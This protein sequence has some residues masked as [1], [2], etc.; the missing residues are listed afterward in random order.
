MSGWGEDVGVEVEALQATYG[1]ELLL[2]EQHQQVSMVMMPAMESSQHFVQ[3]QLLLSVTPQYPQELPGIELVDV[4]GFTNRQDQLMHQLTTEASGLAGELLLGL[5]FE[6]AKTW[7]AEHNHPEGPCI[8]CLEDMAP[9]AGSQ[10]AGSTSGQDANQDTQR[11]RLPCFHAFH[12]ACF[13]DWWCW[14]QQAFTEQQRALEEKTG[15]TAAAALVQE[16][17][18]T[19]D[20]QHF[21]LA[22]PTCRQPFLLADLQQHMQQQLGKHLKQKQQQAAS[23]Q[24]RLQPIAAKLT[25]A[26]LQPFLEV[27]QQH[28]RLFAQQQQRQGIIATDTSY[29]IA[30]W[31]GPVPAGSMEPCGEQSPLAAA[32]ININQGVRGLAIDSQ[33]GHSTGDGQQYRGDTSRGRGRGRGRGRHYNNYGRADQMQQQVPYQGLQQQQQL[34]REPPQ[35]L[36][37]QQ[38]GQQ[39]TSQPQPGFQA[40]PAELE[41]QGRL[42]QQQPGP[43]RSAQHRSQGRTAVQEQHR[44]QRHMQQQQQQQPWRGAR[45][46]SRGGSRGRGREG[47][48]AAFAGN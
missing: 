32:A 46:R 8:F 34:N 35:R 44:D 29:C 15:A 11:M 28:A 45:G 38:L 41:R 43:P 4:K 5:L 23:P 42:P 19:K 27:Q 18:P 24:Q 10:S 9:A 1:E 25:A 13:A 21:Q 16:A 48:E 14:Q 36:Q 31:Q 37:R 33:L 30:D 17:L 40:A 26:Q 12:E 6:S 20:G 7:L 2:D 39:H 47:V 22:C 3:F